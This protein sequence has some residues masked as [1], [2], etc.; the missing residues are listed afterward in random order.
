MTYWVRHGRR[1]T[2]RQSERERERQ[3]YNLEGSLKDLVHVLLFAESLSNIGCFSQP[4]DPA[5]VCETEAERT[6]ISYAGRIVPL[7]HKLLNWTL[8]VGSRFWLNHEFL[9]TKNFFNVQ[10]RDKTF[11]HVETSDFSQGGQ[12]DPWHTAL[13]DNI[14]KAFG[15]TRVKVRNQGTVKIMRYAC[16]FLGVKSQRAICSGAHIAKAFITWRS[17]LSCHGNLYFSKHL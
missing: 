7:L 13:T 1:E 2:Q 17:F 8:L 9:E 14:I 3:Q 15:K 4:W 11:R 5:G 6:K 16:A 10:K 12:Y